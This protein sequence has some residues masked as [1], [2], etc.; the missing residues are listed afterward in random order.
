VAEKATAR[1]AARLNCM[2]AAMW[3]RWE[4][5]VRGNVVMMMNESTKYERYEP[6]Y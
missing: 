3:F 4:V 6:L 2:F 1:R 5:G